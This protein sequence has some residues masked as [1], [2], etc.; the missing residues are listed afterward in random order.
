MLSVCVEM[1]TFR[2]PCPDV[3]NGS[4]CSFVGVGSS[5]TTARRAVRGHALRCH[6]HVYEQ[7]GQPLRRVSPAELEQRLARFRRSQMS[8]AQR[9]EYDRDLLT[10]L[11]PPFGGG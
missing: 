1:S 5:L 6:G 9:Q 7:Q 8:A 4:G 11:G 3:P 10:G 2:V